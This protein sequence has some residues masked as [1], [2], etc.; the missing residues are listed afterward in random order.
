GRQI[1][2][3]RGEVLQGPGGDD[4]TDPLGELVEREPAGR[5]VPLQRVDH[6]LAVFI[7][8][9]HEHSVGLGGRLETSR[10]QV[11]TGPY[12]STW[13]KSHACG[14]R[15]TRWPGGSASGSGALP[16][17]FEMTTTRL[18]VDVYTSLEICS[19]LTSILGSAASQ[20]QDRRSVRASGCA[21][22]SHIR[23]ITG[24]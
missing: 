5:G 23:T 12:R 8:G 18:S 2:G 17:H 11:S 21:R 4:R 15:L 16:R 13:V 19:G 24:P 1:G 14:R 22:T 6:P 3:R 10:R 20:I 7:R 9:A